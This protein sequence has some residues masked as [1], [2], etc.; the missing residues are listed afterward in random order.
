MKVKVASATRMELLKLKKRLALAL[1][2]H[3]LLKDKQD[4]LVRQFFLKQ[5]VYRDHLE[6]VWKAL[7]ESQWAFQML[8]SSTPSRSMEMACRSATPLPPLKED[9]IRILNLMV[10]VLRWPKATPSPTYGYLD[11]AGLMENVLESHLD[12]APLL[13][14]K[15][16]LEKAM[17]DLLEEIEV[18]R[19]RVNALEYKLIP[20]L[21][22]AISV[23]TDKLSELELSELT[24]LMRVKEIISGESS[25]GTQL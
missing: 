13:V 9:E 25:T 15:A 8:K 12:L 10:P 20:M 4:E 19:R 17:R 14:E 18:T 22:E 1:R 5:E 3:K 21:G 23:I 24:R 16:S 7:R 6:K 11:G 2:G